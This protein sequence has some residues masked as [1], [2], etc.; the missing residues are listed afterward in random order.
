LAVTFHQ[1]DFA[2]EDAK[3]AKANPSI[4]LSRPSRLRVNRCLRLGLAGVREGQGSLQ[5]CE[6]V[7]F[8]ERTRG[9]VT[10]HDGGFEI[11]DAIREQRR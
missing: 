8:V 10:G 6:Q 1:E 7:A 4:L 11:A 5:R 2:R 3:V 9:K